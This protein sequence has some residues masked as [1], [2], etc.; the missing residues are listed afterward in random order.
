MHLSRD[1]APSRFKRPIACCRFRKKIC[2]LGN[3][4]CLIKAAVMAVFSFSSPLVA[5]DT[6]PLA[7]AYAPTSEYVDDW[8]QDW[9]IKIHKELLADHKTECEAALRLLDDQLYRITRVVPE[10]ALGQLRETPIWVEWQSDKFPCMCYHVS[11]DWLRENGVNPEKAQ[12]V[13]LA[14]VKNFLDWS[15]D[16]PWMVFHELAHAY[17]DRVLG[18]QNEEIEAAYQLAKTSTRYE[19]VLHIRGNTVRHYALENAGE[20]FAEISES[21]FGVNDF[22]PFVRPELKETDRPG[23]EMLEKLWRVK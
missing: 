4:L 17:H 10:P 1:A 9:K 2:R 18:F 6:P 12:S 11:L 13:E 20:Y 22:F 7:G 21:Y 3:H 14:N 5:E 15:H 8:R 23:Y 16:Q 19:N